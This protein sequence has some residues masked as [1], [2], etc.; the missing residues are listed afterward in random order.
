VNFGVKWQGKL[1]APMLIGK[2][3][4]TTCETNVRGDK[5]I[6]R[7][8]S[9]DNRHVAGNEIQKTPL[10]PFETSCDNRNV[11]PCLLVHNTPIPTKPGGDQLVQYIG[12][13]CYPPNV[14]DSS[15]RSIMNDSP[16]ATIHSCAHCR[17]WSLTSIRPQNSAVKHALGEFVQ[18]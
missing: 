17:R 5:A 12:I 7:G 11:E 3:A 10:W 15:N 14:I 9:R 8:L 1:R 13:Y 6:L 2:G 18:F 16:K 4:R